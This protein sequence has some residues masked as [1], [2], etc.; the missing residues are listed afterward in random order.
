MDCLQ[1]LRPHIGGENNRCLSW[2][3][4]LHCEE[5]SHNPEQQL[6]HRRDS[7]KQLWG[8][9]T[10]SIVTQFH[11]GSKLD[12]NT[13]GSEQPKGKLHAEHLKVCHGKNTF[14]ASRNHSICAVLRP[15]YFDHYEDLNRNRLIPSQ[16]QILARNPYH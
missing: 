5:A 9:E 6:L 1:G 12:R 16:D 2:S 7:T 4:P 13:F 8:L 3:V 10:F 15:P 11:L 14:Q